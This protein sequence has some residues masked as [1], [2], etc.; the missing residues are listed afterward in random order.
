MERRID[1]TNGGILEPLLQF[2]LPV[3]FALFLQSM[4]GAVDL[5]VVGQFATRADVSAVSTGSQIM[6]TVT[7]LIGSLSTGTT[8]LLGQ[9]IGE[10]NAK[11]G[12]R[13]CGASL[14]LFFIIALFFT[15]LLTLFSAPLAH[16]MN[17]PAEAFSLTETYTRICGAGSLVI[18]AYNLIGSIFRGIGDSR[19]PFY[20]VAIACVCNILGDLLL[21]A[22]FEMG[23]AGAAIA[24]VASQFLSVAISL[25]LIRRKSLPFELHRWDIRFH[26][27]LVYQVLSLGLPIAVQDL[28][29][30]MSFLIILAIVNHLGIIASAG[31]GV[32]EKIC[33]FI[34]L[35]PAAFMQSM[36]AF[37][38]QNKGAGRMDRARQGLYY[39]IAVS[40]CFGFC[41]SWTS[42]F[43]GADLAGFFTHEREVALAAADYLKAYSID[44]LLTSF[45]FSFVGFYN[46]IGLT[47]FVMVQGI[48][49]AFG[50]RVPVSYFM[51]L[52]KPVSL[53]H[54][55]LATPCSSAVQ[56]LL[57]LACFYLLHG[58]TRKPTIRTL[59]KH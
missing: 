50:I 26:R 47:R 5:L 14:C 48:V 1:F 30:G 36:S 54:V 32:A 2:A 53:F 19:T 42:F 20:T 12:G 55:G 43:H 39:A 24:T 45:L 34:M 46:G 25:C 23:A 28:L 7:N 35:V 10:G 3:L 29:V 4:Y 22:V 52:Q 13:I 18:I 31:V 11:E 59:W 27:Q 21:V 15:L 51:S 9:K 40:L 49:G 44:C 41:T 38:A 8:V 58:T 57:C 33:G 56:I 17:A 6:Q 16:L 37:A